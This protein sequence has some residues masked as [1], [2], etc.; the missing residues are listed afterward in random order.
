MN[1]SSTLG[2]D[3]VG[4]SISISVLEREQFLIRKQKWKKLG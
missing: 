2:A 4:I 3:F 1:Y